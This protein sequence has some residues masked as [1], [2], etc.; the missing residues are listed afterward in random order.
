MTATTAAEA[1]KSS[2]IYIHVFMELDVGADTPLRMW[3]GPGEKAY[4]GDTYYGIGGI[5]TMSAVESTAGPQAQEV[6]ISLSREGEDFTELVREAM[7]HSIA[8]ND[9]RAFLVLSE[10]DL[11][12]TA[13]A[14]Q[15]EV[16]LLIGKVS[17]V[18]AVRDRI[19]LTV[20]TAMYDAT[21]TRGLA[22]LWTDDQQ[23]RYISGTDRTFRHVKGS[24]GE[25]IAF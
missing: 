23:R 1:A 16:P 17:S 22:R 10:D 2:R 6:T 5:I 24:T 13:T 9:F 19:E 18:S 11:D 3:S 8:D 15:F 14:F 4:G 7:S 20:Y 21:T 12:E 25:E